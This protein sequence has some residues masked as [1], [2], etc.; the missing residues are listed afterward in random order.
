MDNVRV[1]I[2]I[3]TKFVKS[4]SMMNYFVVTAVFLNLTHIDTVLNFSL[5]Y[6]IFVILI[7]AL[8]TN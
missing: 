8:L 6:H 1:S 7:T 3:L 2:K 4:S 5:A